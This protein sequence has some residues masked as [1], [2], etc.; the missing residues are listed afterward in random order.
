MQVIL[1]S[2]D[3]QLVLHGTAILNINF[4]NVYVEY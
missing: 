2:V 3:F 4:F 1:F